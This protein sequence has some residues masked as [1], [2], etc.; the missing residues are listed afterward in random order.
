MSVDFRLFGSRQ[1]PFVAASEQ[2]ECGLACLAAICAY[3]RSPLGL[4]E[5]RELAIHS[6]RGETMLELRNLA[7]RLGLSARGVRVEPEALFK[8][9]MPC[10][11]HWEMNHFVV[12]EKATKSAVVIMD[13][14][15]GRMSLPWSE[16]ENCFTGVVLELIPGER[17]VRTANPAGK[18]SVLNYVGPIARW[19]PELTVILGLSILLEA[20]VLVLPL[21]MRMSVDN[22][23]QTSDGRLILVLGVGFGLLALIQAAI[24]VMRA[25]AV[26]V[27]GA[28]VG[29]DLRDRF[30]R[31]LHAKP[32]Q[33]FS[34]HHTSDLLDR[35][36]SVEVIQSLVTAQLIQSFLDAFMS[37]AMI[38]IMF[39]VMPY[40]AA[41]VAF[42]GL[43]NVGVTAAL[44][45]ATIENSRR[46]LRSMAKADE[47]FLENA[48]AARAIKLFGKEQVRT[49]IWRNRFVEATNLSLQ[50]AR[51]T[52]YSA[53]ASLVTGALSNVALIAAA[54]WMVLEGSLSLGTM[55]M[56]LIFQAI[57]IHRLQ[58]CVNYVMELRRVQ[59]NAERIQEV[60]ASGNAG[61]DSEPRPFCSQP[62]APASGLQIEVR[63]L[64][65]RY[66]N[67]SP[68][69]LKGVN[70]RVE[71]GE[72][73][74]IT[75]ASGSGKSTLM[76]LMLGL[77]RPTK[78]DI[79]IEGRSLSTIASADYA[80]VIGAVMQDDVLFHGTVA[81]NIAFFAMPVN[82][83][84]VREVARM[85][86]ID[87]DINALPMGYYSLLAE[88]AADISGGQK[89]R[90]FIARALY[91]EPRI[92]F[93]DE[94]TSHLDQDSEQQV[95]EAIRSL[96]MT[97]VLIA[98]RRGTI[99]T[100]SRVV[101]LDGGLVCA[102]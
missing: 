20:L 71:P 45:Q 68:W 87:A 6:G 59:T 41:V 67:D 101:V 24:S 98:H 100:A 93:L 21:Q 46:Y 38:L 15:G 51:L 58:S 91:H 7:E 75:G 57:F 44:R 23:V 16:V 30:V 79:L 9:K 64:W 37:L 1:V 29:F 102:P 83:E 14:A 28:R 54:T 8:L 10:I 2:N 74:A 12:L 65:F 34:K 47:S 85:A 4:P 89:Q 81:D 25:W 31:A 18:V 78:G 72:S 19:R 66:G 22:A 97:R 11:L 53:Q 60:L 77:L 5:I 3:H 32:A 35:S 49:S 90:L 17:W 61:S 62:A 95:S 70:L 84:R 94:A 52:L 43:L 86:N 36:H 69:I 88:A 50:N 40:L 63:D 27:F 92:L 33:F 73:L 48:R 55:M 13:P 56:F 76:G 26:S 39:M 96:C 80:R 99:A 42:F 82:N